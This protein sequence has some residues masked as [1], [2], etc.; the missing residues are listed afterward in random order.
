MND[1]KA[2]INEVVQQLSNQIAQLTVSNAIS[3]SL[4]KQYLEQKI[5]ILEEK[6]S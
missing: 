4:I 2:D 3:Q 5:K 6:V 1:I